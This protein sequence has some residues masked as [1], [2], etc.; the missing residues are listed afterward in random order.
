MIFLNQCYVVVTAF[1]YSDAFSGYFYEFTLEMYRIG[2]FTIW[3][4]PDSGWIVESA[5]WPDPDFT[6]YRIVT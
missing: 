2:I 1:V 3:P 5:I 4:D 6:G